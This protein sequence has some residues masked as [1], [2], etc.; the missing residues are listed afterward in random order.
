MCIPPDGQILAMSSIVIHGSWGFEVICPEL[1]FAGQ[2]K[3]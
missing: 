1:T 3:K 2:L